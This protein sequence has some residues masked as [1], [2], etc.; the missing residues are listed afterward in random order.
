MRRGRRDRQSESKAKRFLLRRR[1]PS[2]WPFRGI[3]RAA[4]TVLWETD[5]QDLELV[6]SKRYMASVLD[7][8][9]PETQ[10]QKPGEGLTRAGAPEASQRSKLGKQEPCPRVA[11]PPPA[12][13]VM[14]F[15]PQEHS[16]LQI[17][18]RPVRGQPRAR[19]VAKPDKRR[20]GRLG[21]CCIDW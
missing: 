2:M 14:R 3:H 17:T 11:C 6:T 12:S 5:F 18:S 8:P 10:E 15:R 7:G 4:K 16:F 9:G 20:H 13:L 19:K 21:T 1:R